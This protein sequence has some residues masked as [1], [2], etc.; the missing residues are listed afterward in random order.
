[1]LIGLGTLV[2]MLAGRPDDAMTTDVTTA[3]VLVVAA[4]SPQSAWEHPVFRLLDTVVGMAVGLAGAWVGLQLAPR[5]HA[6][7]GEVHADRAAP[8]LHRGVVSSQR[9]K[10]TSKG[11]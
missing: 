8:H 5:L 9:V 2:M 10:S 7:S 4:L 6:R 1:M 11:A 3:V